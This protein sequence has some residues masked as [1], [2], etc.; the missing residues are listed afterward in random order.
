MK[1]EDKLEHRDRAALSLTI[2]VLDGQF[3]SEMDVIATQEGLEFGGYATIPWK[4]LIAAYRTTWP[5][6]CRDFPLT[7]GSRTSDD[8]S[9]AQ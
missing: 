7:D 2:P 5:Y 3:G 8:E 6:A 1:N 9:G 4:W